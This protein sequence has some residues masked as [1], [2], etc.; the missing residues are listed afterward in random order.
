ME[1]LFV[2]I[3]IGAIALVKWLTS[4]AG[5]NAGEPESGA[6]F[7]RGKNDEE[8][9]M[10][11]FMEALGVPKGTAPP[12][13]KKTLPRTLSRRE[14][15]EQQ[16][17]LV[18]RR[19]APSLATPPPVVPTPA[20]LAPVA[21]P[22]LPAVLQTEPTPA[23]VPTTSRPALDFRALIRSADGLRDAIILREILGPAPG[24]QSL[25]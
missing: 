10:R 21:T 13:R 2:I 22:V 24:L 19:I 25:R 14:V 16:R 5:E 6:P 9:R 18:P 12:V 17:T 23:V 20:P 3:I 4:G 15:V 11:R 7:P 1:Q 8:E